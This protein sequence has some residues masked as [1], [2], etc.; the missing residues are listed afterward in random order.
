MTEA[1]AT[2]IHGDAADM[3]CIGPGEAQLVITSPP[4]FPPKL[5]AQFGGSRRR[6]SDP[7]GTWRH[8]ETFA[9]SLSPVF[10]EIARIVGRTGICCIETKDV[11]YGDFRLPLSALHA[12]LARE[13]GLWTRCSL[14][15]RSTGIKPAHLPNF[16]LRPACG[17]FRTLDTSTLL[18]CSHPRWRSRRSTPMKLDRTT[19]L[20]LIEPYW[21]LTPARHLRIHEHQ[22]P[23]DL[24]R[25]MIELF[26]VPG[27]LVVDPFAGSGQVL[28]IAREL[29][30]RSVGYER[31]LARH[32]AA[33]SLLVG[34]SIRTGAAGAD[35]A[36]RTS[37]A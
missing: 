12:R 25:R 11:V 36:A 10:S 21:R 31:D 16:V 9:T 2:L 8:I 26:S 20:G 17:N 34:R 28:R 30:R 5:V 35:R 27:E 6:Q 37:R 15:F 13:H 33:W 7:E 1:N 32:D 18:I 23:P 19:S 29:Q 14:H 4:Y 3:A 24:I 22:S